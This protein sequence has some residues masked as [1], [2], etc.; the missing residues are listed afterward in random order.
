[1]VGTA[2]GADVAPVN[3]GVAICPEPVPVPLV[4]TG[5]AVAEPDAPVT[6]I[7]CAHDWLIVPPSSVNVTVAP[8]VPPF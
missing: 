2:V 1:M 6:V 4:G 5:V 7:V 3:V 8:N